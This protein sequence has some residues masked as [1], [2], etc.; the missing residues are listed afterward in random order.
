MAYSRCFHRMHCH[1]VILELCARYCCVCYGLYLLSLKLHSLLP[2]TDLEHYWASSSPWSSVASLLCTHTCALSAWSPFSLLLRVTYPSGLSLRHIS[3]KP[4]YPL[5][6]ASRLL[7]VLSASTL[8]CKEPFTCRLSDLG[9]S[10]GQ[11]VGAQIWKY[12][13]VV[14]RTECS[15]GLYIPVERT[16]ISIAASVHSAAT[17]HRLQWV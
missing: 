11:G 16:D 9:A 10:S 1:W 2:N 17:E 4:P 8:H 13:M 15:Q 6:C 3:T 12:R 7:R 5:P 14:G